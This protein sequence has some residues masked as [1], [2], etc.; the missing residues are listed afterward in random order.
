MSRHCSTVNNELMFFVEQVPLQ[1]LVR[2]Q[3]FLKELPGAENASPW[4][5]GLSLLTENDFP[6]TCVLH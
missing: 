3:Q 1:T 4:E 6:D 2:A 5:G